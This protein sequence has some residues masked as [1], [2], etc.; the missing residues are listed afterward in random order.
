MEQETLLVHGSI[1]ILLKKFVVNTYTDTTWLELN[2]MAGTSERVYE[3]N[4]SYPLHEM[5][6]IVST[7]ATHIGLSESDLKE[8]FG[9]YLVPDLFNLYKQYL[10][11]GWKTFETLENTEKIMHG[12]VRSGGSANPPVLNVSRVNDQLLYIDYY[13]KRKMG[14]LAIG[15]IKGIAKYFNESDQ[16]QITSMS[17]PNDE[18][19]QIK[20]KFI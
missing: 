16:I 17:N 7:A 13:S 8:K 19:V 15:I 18:R 5:D 20:V 1:F 4:Q 3:M 2:R 14:S 10:N 12:A 9:E 11:P 6:S